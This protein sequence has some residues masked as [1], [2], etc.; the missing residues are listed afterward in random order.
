M[1]PRRVMT[2]C[3]RKWQTKTETADRGTGR[4]EQRHRHILQRNRVRLVTSLVLEDLWDRL[5]E[6]EVFSTDMVEEIQAAG[7]RRDQARQLLIDLQSRGSDAFHLFLQCLR[8]S[9]QHEL[10]DLLQETGGTREVK[11]PALLPPTPL[12]PTLPPKIPEHRDPDRFDETPKPLDMKTDYPMNFDP[13]GRCLIINNMA[14]SEASGLSYRT[15]SDIDREK[16]LRRLR[17][18]HFDVT[19]K[20]NLK[21]AEIH[22]ELQSL[23]SAEHSERD[24]CL[25][26]ILSHGCE[27]R[28]TRFPGGVFGTDGVRIPVE[29]IVNYFN[30]SNCPGLR[31][32]PKLFFI[33]A[34]GGGVEPQRR[35]TEVALWIWGTRGNGPVTLRLIPY[36]VTPPPSPQTRQTLM[37]RTLRPSC[38]RPATSWC[39]IPPTQVLCLGGRRGAALGTW[40]IWTRSWLSA[41]GRAICSRCW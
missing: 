15:G 27:T 5:L 37:R 1:A 2:S 41:P 17:S 6:K 29:R 28:H 32:K 13:C 34:C 40:R 23:A 4:M 25:V 11:R 36:K 8:G 38:P 20:N 21:A 18:Y 26:V 24:C 16:L 3:L 35:R 14:F 30:G 39:P 19:V 9:G 33:Q 31:G 10:A 7:T 22:A 12:P